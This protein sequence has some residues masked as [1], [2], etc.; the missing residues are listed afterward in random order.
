MLQSKLHT[1]H[2]LRAV[3]YRHMFTRRDRFAHRV[4]RVAPGHE[5][6]APGDVSVALLFCARGRIRI[7]CAPQGEDLSSHDS[8][9]LRERQRFSLNGDA[10]AAGMF[11]EIFPVGAQP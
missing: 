11:I 3:S 4:A 2:V 1:M 5:L 10:S 9:I 6:V 7:E 8:V